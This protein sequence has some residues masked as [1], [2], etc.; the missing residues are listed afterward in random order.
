MCHRNHSFLSEYAV[1]WISLIDITAKYKYIPTFLTYTE[2]DMGEI[3]GIGSSG[4]GKLALLTFCC[5]SVC[6]ACC[7]C[8]CCF[9]WLV[10]PFV[11]V[12]MVCFLFIYVCI[13]S[14][15]LYTVAQN[16]CNAACDR[17][18]RLC[19]SSDRNKQSVL[20]HQ[21][22][23]SNDYKHQLLTHQKLTQLWGEWEA[24]SRKYKR[25]GC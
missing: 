17:Q 20:L 16:P 8:D 11:S 21:L 13:F 1:D 7:T 2:V 25:T 19:V 24:R 6:P 9:L 5:K 18:H 4:R 12:P 15:L 3:T 10:S 23:T 14:F 22:V